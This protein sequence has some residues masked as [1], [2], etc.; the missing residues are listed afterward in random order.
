LR[1]NGAILPTGGLIFF[2][3]R[4]IFSASQLNLMPTFFGSGKGEI[5]WRWEDADRSVAK[6]GQNVGYQSAYT[7]ETDW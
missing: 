5:L 3:F 2:L 4:A 6:R 7:L 1:E